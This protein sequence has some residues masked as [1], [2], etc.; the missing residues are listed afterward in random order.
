MNKKHFF[1]LFISLLFIGVK[2]QRKLEAADIVYFT[3]YQDTLRYLQKLVFY[4]KDDSIKVKSNKQFIDVWEEVLLNNL[5]F[6]FPFD[7]LKDVARL[8]S[9]DK[10]FR[11]I[12]WDLNRKDGSHFYFGFIQVQTEKGKFELYKLQDRSGTIK[13]PETHTGDHTK[14]FGMLYYKIIPCD[15][16]YALL[17]WDG[18]DKLTCRKFID[19]LS[20]KDNA[21]PVFGKDVFKMPRG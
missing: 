3:K 11:I 1:I 14:W 21:E 20:F 17:A 9:P 6:E 8:T 13:S 5:S 2:A 16:Y 19:V 18:N 15:D 10:K 12:N 4:S 7:S